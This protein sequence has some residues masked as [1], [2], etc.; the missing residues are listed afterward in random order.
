MP[1]PRFL[2]ISC[3][4]LLLFSSSSASE[5]STA[6]DTANTAERLRR[7]VLR[8]SEYFDTM[9][10][11]VL[12]EHNVTLHFTPKFSDLRD[13]EYVRYPL[14]LRYGASQNLEL[15]A[16]LNPFSPNPINSGHDHRW[17]P[18]EAKLGGRYDIDGS[19]PFFDDTTLGLETRVPL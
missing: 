13:N 3:L 2:S 19:L 9:L 5:P 1:R 4:A 7:G 11:G 12:Q 6:P 18:G 14:E 8:M 15:S 10:P 17:G 16:G